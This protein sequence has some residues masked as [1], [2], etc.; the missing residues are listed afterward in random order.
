MCN[1][2]NTYTH[3]Q[4]LDGSEDGSGDED[5]IG[6]G[7][8]EAKKRKKPYKSCRRHVG[9]GGDLGVKRKKRRKERIGPVAVNLDSL[10]N[11]VP[12]AQ[13]RIKLYKKVCPLCRV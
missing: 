6:E 11:K 5:R 13:V 2:I 1:L 4:R 10:E 7:G 3:T 8:I 9:N 12:R